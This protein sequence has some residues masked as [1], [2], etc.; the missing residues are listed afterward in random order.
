MGTRFSPTPTSDVPCNDKETWLNAPKEKQSVYTVGYVSGKKQEA[1]RK[2]PAKGHVPMRKKAFLAPPP[3]SPF[4]ISVF[5]E[6]GREFFDFSL[7]NFFPCCMSR[8]LFGLILL[9]PVFLGALIPPLFVRGV[10]AIFLCEG[11]NTSIWNFRRRGGNP[12]W[13]TTWCRDLIFF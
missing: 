11:E 6:K 7:Q 10:C 2:C 3:P 1:K 13:L 9:S 4:G 5:C 8:C 12:P